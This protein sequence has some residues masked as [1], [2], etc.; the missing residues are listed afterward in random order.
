VTGSRP[1]SAGA[2]RAG[3]EGREPGAAEEGMEKGGAFLRIFDISS[4]RNTLKNDKSYTLQR[5]SRGQVPSEH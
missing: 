3:E 1:R 2:L 4:I 5:D